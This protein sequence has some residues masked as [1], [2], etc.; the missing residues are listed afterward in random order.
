MNQPTYVLRPGALWK[1]I[2]PDILKEMRK[3]KTGIRVGVAREVEVDEETWKQY[4]GLA[5]MYLSTNG[6]CDDAVVRQVKRVR[7]KKRFSYKL[8]WKDPMYVSY[9][10]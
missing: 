3:T 5:K 2:H 6:A 1:T 4:A 7:K 9:R 10:I 8:Y